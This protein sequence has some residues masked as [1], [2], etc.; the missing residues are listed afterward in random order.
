M[1]CELYHSLAWDHFSTWHL[2]KRHFGTDI[3]SPHFD[4][5][6]AQGRYGVHWNISTQGFFSTVD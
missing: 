5:I 3:L 4:T 1:F 2:G 6:L